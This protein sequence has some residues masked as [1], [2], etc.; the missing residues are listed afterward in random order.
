VPRRARAG[1]DDD[2][3]AEDL[4]LQRLRG[5]LPANS[6]AR[7]ETRSAERGAWPRADAALER[8]AGWGAADKAWKQP[9]ERRSGGGW[10]S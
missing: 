1:G 6:W 3:S 2:D 7:D 5:A 4:Q 8:G 10:F 9:A